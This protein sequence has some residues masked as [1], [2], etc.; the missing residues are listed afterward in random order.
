[1]KPNGDVVGV[2]VATDK[3]EPL[4]YGGSMSLFCKYILQ[5]AFSPL[6]RVDLDKLQVEHLD[7]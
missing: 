2:M 1:M 7:N 3:V 4:C 5:R 6:L